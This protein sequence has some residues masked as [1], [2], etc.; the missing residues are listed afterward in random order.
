MTLTGALVGLVVI[1]AGCG[2]S[3]SPGLAGGGGGTSGGSSSGALA[4]FEAYAK[5]MRGHR[6]PDFPDPTTSP[7]GGVA[8]QINGG[9]G[10]DLNRNNPRFQAA[11]QACHSLEPGG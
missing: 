7:G 2:G 10:S 5:C 6:I 9:P 8:I 11:N 1:V 3:K 4:Q